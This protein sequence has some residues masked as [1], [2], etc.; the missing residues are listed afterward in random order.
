MRR[1]DA[2]RIQESM[3]L[4]SPVGEWK[5]S[6]DFITPPL[7]ADKLI[8]TQ[9]T[10]TRKVY[11]EHYSGE[12]ASLFWGDASC[13]TSV[14]NVNFIRY[15]PTT[16]PTLT[17][18]PTMTPTRTATSTGT[19]TMT[20]SPTPEPAVALVLNGQQF[21]SGDRL[22]LGI[23]VRVSIWAKFDAYLL[24]QTP[25]G[26]YRIMLGG[27]ARPGIAPLVTGCARIDAPFGVTVLDD[28][29][30]PRSMIGTTALYLVTVYAGRMPAVSDVSQLT[31]HTQYVITLDKRLLQVR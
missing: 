22:T 5:V 17:A 21:V 26:M 20:P 6:R 11:S 8:G 13:Q 12:Y 24:A 15:T 4:Y 19:P 23:R 28:Y 18:T 14:R 29:S 10:L 25:A 1:T 7:G 30:L 31:P 27:Q 3:V 16:T 9:W 2:L